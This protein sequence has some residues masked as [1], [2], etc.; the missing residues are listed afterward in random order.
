MN[1]P[2]RGLPGL[3]LFLV[4]INLVSVFA[5][6]LSLILCIERV[7]ACLE[8]SLIVRTGLDRQLQFNDYRPVIGKQH[9][10]Y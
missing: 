10:W 9:L 3:F 5:L 6:R 8:D 4:A 7:W 1:N 2:E